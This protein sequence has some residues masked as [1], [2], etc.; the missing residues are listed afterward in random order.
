MNRKIGKWRPSMSLWKFS[1]SKLK[2]KLKRLKSNLRKNM[3][4]MVEPMEEE[5]PK[6]RLRTRGLK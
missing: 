4:T 5:M 6:R 1:L 3:V 2:G